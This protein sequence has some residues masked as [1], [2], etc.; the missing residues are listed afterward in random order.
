MADIFESAKI[1]LDKAFQYLE[2]SDDAKEILN[3]PKEVLEVS[4]PVRMDNRELKVYKGYRVRYNDV[5]GPTKGGIRYHPN[6]TLEEVK[7]LAFWMTFKCAVLGL[8]YG[9]GKGG[10]IVNP[11]EMSKQ[12]I[13]Y[14]S[15]GYISAIYDFIGPERDIPAPDVYTNETIMGWMADEY[16]KIAR[17]LTP[18][19]VTGKPISL[20]GSL[21]RSDATAR[22]GYYILKDLVKDLKLDEKELTVAIQG[23]GNAGYNIAKLL[24]DDGYKIIAI[25]DS[26]GGIVAKNGNTLHPDSIMKIKKEKGEIDGVYCNG[27]VCDAIEHDK[28]SYKDVLEQDVDILIPAAVENQITKENAD[29]IKAK[30]ILELANGPITSDADDILDKKSTIVIPDILANAGGVTV[31]YFEWLQNKSGEY[32]DLEV[33]H[34]KLKEKMI[35]AFRSVEKIKKE[36]NINFRTASY[37]LAT[38]RIV[39]AIDAK[40]TVEYYNS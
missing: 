18:G 20:G 31:S 40:G 23:F 5:L 26:K 36:N 24:H 1:Q 9:G 32:W 16:S 21:G 8:P 4:I 25:S 38:K 12:E 37:V 2:V 17:Q 3:A 33:V 35:K 27:S 6:V 30:I 34:K 29:K 13:E 19:I 22:G 14:L 7:A 15:R 39:D 11:K 10:V 28:I